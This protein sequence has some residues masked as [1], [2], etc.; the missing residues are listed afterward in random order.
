MSSL[1]DA[2]TGLTSPWGY[3][4]VALLAALE[5]A[6]F[7]G[8]IIPGEAAMLTG[9][10]LVYQGHAELVPMMAAA[11]AGGIVGDSLAYELGHRFGPRLR[12]GWFGRRVGAA[13]RE[14]AEAALHR[15]G[16]VA[17]FVGRFIGVLRA[18]VPP[19]AGMARMPYRRFLIANAAGGLLW[20]PA[21][22]AAGYLAGG[23][24]RHLG[25]PVSLAGLVLLGTIA[26]VV[27]GRQARRPLRRAVAVAVAGGRR[28]GVDAPQMWLAATLAT[29]AGATVALAGLADA[30]GDHD[31][32]AGVDRSITRAVV[33]HRI[34]ALN[35]VFRAV[36]WLGSETVLVPLV[37]IACG[38][39]VWRTANGW[40]RA[41][42]FA[43]AN[44]GAAALAWLLK[45]LVDRARPPLADRLVAV[46]SASFPSGHATQAAAFF[47]GLA[48]LVVA[49]HASRRIMLLA[50]AGAASMSVLVGASRVYLGVHWASDVV[51]GYLLAVAWLAALG[52]LVAARAARPS[53]AAWHPM[54]VPLLRRRRRHAA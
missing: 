39:L 5:A 41:G 11:A 36:T 1:L 38:L 14:R 49:S 10:F 30:V 20:G 43:A 9:G 35:T 15:N 32:L 21:L 28:L 22:V 48:L 17:V 45:D 27:A 40:R 3:L 4:L 53:L 29:L 44:S 31:E 12:S 23:S 33:D 25:A 2:L 54:I 6:A 8:L 7:V 24:Y 42:L 26:V 19:L 50:V 47:G 16:A 52:S 13:R 37:V 46:D 34:P 18:L 51:A